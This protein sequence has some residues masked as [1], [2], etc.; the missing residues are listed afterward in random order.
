MFSS[1]TFICFFDIKSL[2]LASKFI[3]SRKKLMHG[4]SDKIDGHLS[5]NFTWMFISSNIYQ[6]QQVIRFLCNYVMIIWEIWLP[7]SIFEVFIVEKSKL[8]N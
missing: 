2:E 5:S 8:A 1:I 6:L 7:L 3:F 4:S